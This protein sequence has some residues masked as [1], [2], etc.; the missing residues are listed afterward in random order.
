MS[1]QLTTIDQPITIRNVFP[2]FPNGNPPKIESP[3]VGAIEKQ[4]RAI[5]EPTKKSKYPDA[6]D[7]GVY[8][9]I[10]ARYEEAPRGGVVFN[11]GLKLVNHHQSCSKCH[12]AFEIDT[13]GRGCIHNCVYCYAKEILTRHGWW[14]AP[15]PFPLNLAEIRKIFYTVFETDKP[16]RWR[17][18]MDK[19]VPLRLGSMSDCFMWMDKKYRITHEFLK[20]LKFYRYP[21]IIF[22]RSDLVAHEDYLQVLDP[23]LVSVQFSISGGNEQ[24]TRAIEPGAPGVKRRLQALKIL[25]ESGFWTTVRIN[26]FLPMYPDGYFTDEKSIIER[27]GSKN[28][29]P[30]FDLF[31]WDFISELKAAKVPS[32]LVGFARLNPFAIRALTKETGINFASFFKPELFK[33]TAESRYTDSEIAYY[34]K[35]IQQE[36]V[37]NDIRFQTC[38]I[39]MGMKD[40][41]QYQNL[42][43]NKSDCC[44]AR[45]NVD[46]FKASSQDVPWEIRINHAAQKQ[47]AI[48]TQKMEKL[49]DAEYAE[50]IPFAKK[51]FLVS[52]QIDPTL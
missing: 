45:G 28:N 29:V 12:Y 50:S 42:W 13:Y 30:K 15:Q 39:G 43:S 36:C 32:I 33:K 27:F 24:L 48:E 2:I 16:S 35:R 40:Y 37:K 46:K 52:P 41:Y 7:W 19:K 34:Y 49:F 26:P 8:D 44:D 6:F 17:D 3:S 1:D 21:H 14:N 23:E 9:K 38:F 5:L 51:P 25:A 31:E 4:M 20:I 47:S 11:T 22:T 18:I 10:A